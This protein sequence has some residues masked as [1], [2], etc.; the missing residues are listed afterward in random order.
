M[1]VY[2]PCHEDALHRQPSSPD[3]FWCRPAGASPHPC[4]CAGAPCPDPACTASCPASVAPSAIAGGLGLCVRPRP[5]LAQR[6][7]IT[8]TG[9]MEEL[10]YRLHSVSLRPPTALV[11]LCSGGGRVLPLTGADCSHSHGQPPS[12][13]DNALAV[14]FIALVLVHVLPVLVEL[15]VLRPALPQLVGQSSQ[16]LADYLLHHL[17]AVVADAPVPDV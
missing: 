17:A 11:E 4:Q 15:M 14:A 2:E 9:G 3:G 8:A 16:L 6:I 7:V 13:L 10:P 1:T 5:L 12:A